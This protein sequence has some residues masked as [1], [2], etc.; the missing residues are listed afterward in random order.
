MTSP[1]VRYLVLWLT[2][3]CNMRCRYCYRSPEVP[4]AMPRD[5]ALAALSLAAASGLPFHVQLAGGEPTVQ[6]GL[7]EFV[8]RTVREAGWP[9]TVALQTNGTLID[10][11]LG[12]LCRRYGIGVGVSLDGPPEVQEQLRGQAGATFRGLAL[13]EEMSIPVRVTTVLSSVNVGRLYD[14]AV[15]LARFTNI[16]GVGL[17]PLVLAGAART[18]P[19]LSPSP[20]AVRS[21]VR[22]LFEAMEW[23]NRDC[24]I[25]IEWRESDAVRR[26]LLGSGPVRP[27]CHACQG[28]S[29]AVHPSGAVYPCGQTIGDPDMAAGAI[30]AVD[31]ERLRTYYQ[32]LQ[33]HGDCTTCPLAGRCPGD[34]PSR[35]HYNNGA[36]TPAM[37]IVYQA[38]AE[39][40]TGKPAG[41]NTP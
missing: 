4:K 1:T 20:E 11:N 15:C 22:A 26:A 9:A 25:P 12:D 35:L 6:P 33:F 18:T 17:D 13:L 5:I 34:C 39:M 23:I 30:D 14:L 36:G 24:A 16:R 38:I 37:C 21:G 7:I 19:D 8:G 28:E 40:L 31:W 32:G 3:A 41:R 27:Y 2:T 10:R 29:L